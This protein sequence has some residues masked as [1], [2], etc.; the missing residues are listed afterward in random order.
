LDSPGKFSIRA[1][2]G[3]I[4]KAK[5]AQLFV[6]ANISFSVSDVFAILN[7]LL[8]IPFDDA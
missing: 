6:E 7:A 1:L 4:G 2:L 3:V 8:P 5:K